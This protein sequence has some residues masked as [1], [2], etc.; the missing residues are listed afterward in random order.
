MDAFLELQLKTGGIIAI[1]VLVYSLLLSRDSFF[2]RNRAWL[3]ATVIVPWIV[4]LL[5]M[6]VWLKSLLYQPKESAE[7]FVLTYDVPIT[8]VSTAPAPEPINWLLIGIS[9]YAAVSLILALRLIWGYVI[10]QR[11]RKKGQHMSYKGYDI[12]L[13]RNKDIN[14]FSFYR[15]IYMPKHLERDRNRQM[16]LEHER[17]H[18]AQLHS[19]DIS[20]AEWLLIIQWWN[21]FVWWLR[22]LIAQNHEYCVDNAMI[23]ITE[24]PKVYQYSLL[25]LLNSDRR[26]QLVNNFNQ[27]LTKKRLVM[28]NK[29]HTNRLIGWSKGLLLVP[30]VIAALLAFTDPNKTVVEAKADTEIRS[31]LDLRKHIAKTIKYPLTARDAGY[32]TTISAYFKID[33]NGNIGKVNIGKK[34]GAKQLEKVVVVAYAGDSK[35]GSDKKADTSILDEVLE[36][37]VIRVLNRLP[38]VKD[39]EWVDRLLQIDV[40]FKLQRKASD[41]GRSLAESWEGK[42]TRLTNSEG[43]EY[44][45]IANNGKLNINGPKANRPILV[46]DGKELNWS[47]LS[48]LDLDKIKTIGKSPA[49]NYVKSIDK[50]AENGAFLL[51]SEEFLLAI[52]KDGK[53]YVSTKPGLIIVDGEK[54]DGDLSDISPDQIESMNVLK[55]EA[56]IAKYGQDAKEGAIELTLKK[57][58]NGKPE[59]SAIRSSESKV[60]PMFIVDGKE[61]SESEF[62]NLFP[63]NYHSETKLK[64]QAAV[65]KYGEKARNGVIVINTKNSNGTSGKRRMVMGQPMKMTP[66]NVIR[67]NA[68]DKNGPLYV[69]DGDKKTSLDIDP[70]QVNT[71]TVLKGEQAEKLYGA[72]PEKGVILVTT[73]DV[74]KEDLNHIKIRSTDSESVQIADNFNGKRPYILLD[75]KEFDGSMQDVD[76]YKVKSISVLKDD[77]ATALYGDKAKDGVIMITSKNVYEDE[78][79]VIAYGTMAKGNN[80]N[81]GTLLT[82]NGSQ[83]ENLFLKGSSGN[84]NPYIVLDGEEFAGDLKDI[85]NED[86]ESISV[87]KDHAATELYGDKGKNGV[88]VIT[89]KIK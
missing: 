71:V 25:N 37:E 12:V 88:I 64:G 85:N 33:K 17:R 1:S 21:P 39:K 32:E 70:K 66:E 44:S 26:M 24:E 46:L 49:G 11:L 6:P 60:V 75:G 79:K 41:L 9:L 69:V 89:S 10:I 51:H 4:P 56:A 53:G 54:F 3:L 29:K 86:I 22:K 16:I 72:D 35:K 67:I 23:Q 13:L 62:K 74:G 63:F 76:P 48:T 83:A 42:E 43:Q 34:T 77:Q 8:N 18:C 7:A 81:L 27:S 57:D 2:Q 15:T 82:R 84:N 19:I 38:V 28:M 55:G 78:V 52:I 14:P 58:K 80:S 73:K 87:L 61:L 36:E 68:A 31:D 40:Q 20:L 47:D 30:V 45:L 5:A 65:D 59:A 50:K